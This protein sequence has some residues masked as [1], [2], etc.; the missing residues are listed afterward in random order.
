[1]T[2]GIFLAFEG[3]DASGKTTIAKKIAAQRGALFTFEPGDTALGKEL[4]RWLLDAKTPM[5]P[6]T[7]ALLM[8][9]DRAHHVRSF[10]APTL[11]SG[12]HVVAD[13]FTP[14]T[15]AYQGYGRGLDLAQLRA[16]SELAVGATLPDLTILIDV[17]IEVAN[18]RRARDHKDRFESADVTFHER[19]REGYLTMASEDPEHWVVIDGS[20][21]VAQVTAAV[22][23]RLA[24]LPWS[25]A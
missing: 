14:S 6:E 17:T 10:I 1:M 15:L 2:R 21:T 3:I 5:A 7:E 25:H 13:R 18:Q 9:A 24:H 23:E 11:A 22:E 19:V 20:G 4:R 8:M 16:A 12:Q